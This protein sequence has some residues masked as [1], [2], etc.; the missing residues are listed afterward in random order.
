MGFTKLDSGIVQSSIMQE[1]P[2][3]FKAWIVFLA[4]CDPDGVSR[5][6][7]VYISSIC[8]FS[9]ERTMEIIR[10]LESPDPLSRSIND[11]GKRIERVDGGY[12]IINYQKYREFTYSK[13]PDALRK[14]KKREEQKCE[15]KDPP[16]L[17]GQMWTK[18]DMSGRVRT[19]VDNF[20][21]S[22]SASASSSSLKKD[23]PPK[24]EDLIMYCRERGGTVDPQSFY[25]FYSSKGWMVGKNKMVDWKAA[26]RTWEKDATHNKNQGW[27]PQ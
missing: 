14:R 7:P 24:K 26:V 17:S 23:I 19:N 21:H 9:I 10:L 1:D 27:K 11:D 22:A 20:G 12:R 16:A 3:V 15:P 2:E 4:V 18:T 25:D 5:V 6:S 8:H 13:S